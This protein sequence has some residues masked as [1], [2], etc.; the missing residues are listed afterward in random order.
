MPS[1]FI[2]LTTPFKRFNPTFV[3]KAVLEISYSI[4][5]Y[6]F[7]FGYFDV[8]ERIANLENTL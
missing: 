6:F 4:Q 8:R 5:F 2:K 1:M 7:I 3:E